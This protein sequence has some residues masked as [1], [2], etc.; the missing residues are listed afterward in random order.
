LE[1]SPIEG[2]KHNDEN[3]LDLDFL[4]VDEASML[5]LLLTNN[6][7]KAVQPGTHVLFV[8]DVDQLP[9]VGAGDVLRDLIDSN[10]VPVT[11]LSTIFRQ[12]AHSKIITNAHLINQGKL[13][14][15][16][17]GEGTSSC[18]RRRCS[19]AAGGSS[20]RHRTDPTEVRL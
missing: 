17:Q 12:A 5:D 6:L 18:F 2:F 8:G 14:V 19:G 16:S 10:V 9:S 4:V 15:F 11:R 7:L 1:Y 13:P 3:P 20:D